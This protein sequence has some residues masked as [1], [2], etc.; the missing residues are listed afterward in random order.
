MFD[1]ADNAD[2]SN[3]ASTAFPFINGYNS[4]DTEI[5]DFWIYN[6][7]SSFDYYG[8]NAGMATNPALGFTLKG[9]PTRTTID[10][11]GRPK[12]G[13]MSV[14]VDWNGTSD[15]TQGG[16][17]NYDGLLASQVETLVGNPYPCTLDLKMFLRIQKKILV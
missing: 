5:A 1:P 16:T 12:T 7:E 4:T 9:R 17:V 15:A 6:T 8:W 2:P 11:R 13:T 10:Y 14:N 3:V